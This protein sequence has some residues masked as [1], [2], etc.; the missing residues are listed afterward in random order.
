ML[1]SNHAH[2]VVPVA[3]MTCGGCVSKLETALRAADGIEEVTVTLEPA[4]A[5]IRGSATPK[6]IHA[7]IEKSGFQ[8]VNSA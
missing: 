1:Q 3:G 2:L 6:S 8:A 5:I 4:Q 7:L